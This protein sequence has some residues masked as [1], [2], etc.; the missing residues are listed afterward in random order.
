M[1]DKK[2]SKY[3]WCEKFRPAS[4][5]DVLLSSSMKRFFKK[6]VK[7]EQVPNLLFYSTSPGT[8]KT[9][10]AKALC[11][12]IGVDYLYINTSSETGIDILRT[13]I[14]KYACVKTLDGKNKVA[15]LDEFDGSTPNL[16][17]G[18]RAAIEEFH[19]SCRFIFA[20]NYATKIIEPL[21]S[22][23]QVVDFNL[24]DKKTKDEMIPKI[25]KRLI[26]ILKNENVEYNTETL[27]KLV[28]TF[29]PDM[30]KM[31]QLLQQYYNTNGIIDNEI[32]T[33][34]R[35]DEEFFTYIL[36]KDLTNARKYLIE[37]NSNP[38]EVYRSL[39]DNFIPRLE[40]DIQGQAILLIAEYLYRHAF[41]VDPEINITACLLEIIGLL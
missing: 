10:V 37:R 24:T 4:I 15:I 18:L 27:D 7:D 23:C 16:Q 5:K 33:Y 41:S 36:N 35:I 25:T 13:K 17:N 32:F 8:G 9:T 22:R 29:Y 28:N 2:L 12:D 11:K 6:I 26:G 19:K 21:K 39:F 3:L 20:V 14:Q 31:I 38:V 40:K 1:L 34:E 30:R